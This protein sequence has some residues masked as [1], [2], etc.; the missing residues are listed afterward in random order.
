MH[1]V[2]LERPWRDDARAA[3]TVGLAHMTSHFFQLLLPPIYP[4]L[5]RD[6]GI[7]FT[8]AGFLATVFFV[9]SS[10]GQAL[11]GFA[12]DRFGALRIL[13][14]G[15]ALLACSGV[16]LGLSHSYAGL[17]ATAALAGAGN[18]IFHPAD[19]TVLNRRV[20]PSRLGHAFAMHGLTGNL[21][22]VA[23]S[24][25]MAAVASA[26][27]WHLAGFGAAAIAL[28]ALGFLSLQRDVFEGPAGEALA[29]RPSAS[30]VG[31]TSGGQFAFLS[32]PT[33]WL[34]FAFFFLSTGAGGIL[35]NFAPAMLSNVYPVTAVFGTMCLA[36]Y[37][38]GSATGTV[39]GGFVAGRERRSARVVALALCLSA[40]IALLLA[41][42]GCQWRCSRRHSS[43]S[44]AARAPPA[45]AA[46][47]SC[48]R[49]RPRASVRSP[50]AACTASS[51][52]DSTVASRR[53]RSSSGACST[54][55]SFAP[56]CCASPSCRSAR[57]SSHSTSA[58][59]PDRAATDFP[60]YGLSFAMRHALWRSS[61]RLSVTGNSM[62]YCGKKCPNNC[63][64][65]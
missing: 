4:W 46:T 64:S 30:A 65:K 15:I 14:A 50:S 55:G 6:F 22:W 20:S 62:P 35:Q 51:T 8:E 7:G 31:R 56:G 59:G 42:A 40:L 9:I 60:R 32:S 45:R 43:P 36:S 39:L 24:S 61:R 16:M 29:A 54:T 23:G 26:A 38:L 3:A 12:V 10:A 25:F 53:C 17:L 11:A 37:L 21:G 2:S 41:S 49:R 33:V 34:C 1:A 58:A 44:V 28:G 27:D 47:C 13:Q 19:F 18:A 5:M 52:P 57:C 48:A 63:F